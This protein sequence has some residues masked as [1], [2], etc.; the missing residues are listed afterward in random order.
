MLFVKNKIESQLA[1]RILALEQ[2]A[3]RWQVLGEPDDEDWS[4][5]TAL[6]MSG[7]GFHEIDKW[8]DPQLRVHL[9]APLIENKA[10][11]GT[12]FQVV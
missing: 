9:V 2:L 3:G 8:V 12:S 7:R 1:E 6:A 5:D 4:S 11:L 10:E